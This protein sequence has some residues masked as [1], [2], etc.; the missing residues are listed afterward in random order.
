MNALPVHEENG[1]K[2]LD[3]GGVMEVLARFHKQALDAEK[4][5][6]ATEQGT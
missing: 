3:K 5:A 2:V 4:A 6:Q 1:R